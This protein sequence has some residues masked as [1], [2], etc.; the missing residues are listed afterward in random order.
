[1]T[2]FFESVESVRGVIKSFA[3]GVIMT[4]TSA[5]ALINNLTR[6]A[7]LYAA[8]PAVI[9]KRICLPR[10]IDIFYCS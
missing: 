6:D 8:I 1:M 2:G 9:P 7:V 10:R 4:L 3:A 5:P